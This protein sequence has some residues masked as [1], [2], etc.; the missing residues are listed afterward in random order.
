[1]KLTSRRGW[2]V[3]EAAGTRLVQA[4]TCKSNT[5]PIHR[6]EESG[7]GERS[8]VN[9]RARRRTDGNG[10]GGGGTRQ[11]RRRRRRWG[12]RVSGG[13][14]GWNGG[15]GREEI[16]PSWRAVEPWAGSFGL[17]G[18]WFFAIAYPSC[19]GLPVEEL[20]PSRTPVGVPRWRWKGS[21]RMKRRLIEAM[22]KWN[23]WRDF[24][25]LSRFLTKTQPKKNETKHTL[26]GFWKRNGAGNVRLNP[27]QVQALP[28]N[29]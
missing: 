6:T 17:Y 5:K 10:L 28:G 12:A 20:G 25:L 21:E 19:L 22:K 29:F 1:M 26:G 4:R 13:R 11:K 15:M 27:S 16:R 2:L 3:L 24:S 18:P 8:R 23:V 14:R 7:R 9:E